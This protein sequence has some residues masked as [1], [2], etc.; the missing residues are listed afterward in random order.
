M[1]I[2]NTGKES[3]ALLEA[4]FE[5]LGKEAYLER[6]IDLAHVRGL[7]PGVRG[8]RFPPMPSDYTLTERGKVSYAEVKSSTSRTSF[9]LS[10]IEPAQWA[11]ARRVTLAGGDYWFF[12]HNKIEDVW[13]KV[14]AKFL[15]TYTGKKSVKWQELEPFSW[16]ITKNN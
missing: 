7:N 11:A 4:H 2:S 15:L 13:F 8:L 12:I 3:E 1:S 14:P 10:N 9:S 16:L 6:R 5:A